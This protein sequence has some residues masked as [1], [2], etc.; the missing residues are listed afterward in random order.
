M[1]CYIFIAFIF[2]AQVRRFHDAGIKARLPYGKTAAFVL[3]AAYL[4]IITH[5]VNSFDVSMGFIGWVL[6]LAYLG[7]A[8][9]VAV[10]ACRD[11][12][13]GSNKYGISPKYRRKIYEK[14]PPP[15]PAPKKSDLKKMEK[16]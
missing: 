1:P 9:A 4:W 7:L 8:V 6:L 16:K 12:E 3:L 11:S 13:K 10:I 5:S 15:P 2:S 14:L